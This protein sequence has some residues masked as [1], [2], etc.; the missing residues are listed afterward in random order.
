[1]GSRSATYD[2][3]KFSQHD[4]CGGT[5][6]TTTNFL[7]VEKTLLS[8][9]KKK[10]KTPFFNISFD[11]Y[12]T[13]FLVHNSCLFDVGLGTDSSLERRNPYHMNGAHAF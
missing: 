9:F 5:F 1:M 13:Q 6:C 12:Y 8:K 10:K 2:A 11:F 4:T 7:K 3:G